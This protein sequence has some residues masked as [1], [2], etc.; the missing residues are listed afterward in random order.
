MA[1]PK[2]NKQQREEDLAYIA[3]LYLQGKTHVEIAYLVSADRQYTLTK[4]TIGRD[5]GELNDRWY[6]A[7]MTDIDRLKAVQ[8]AKVDE[9]EATAWEGWFKSLQDKTSQTTQDTEG[10]KSTSNTTQSSSGDPRFLKLIDNCIERRC[11]ILGIDAPAKVSATDNEGRPSAGSF[12]IL[13]AVAG[14]LDE[15]RAAVD[16]YEDENKGD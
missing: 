9:L 13:P 8:L 4:Q 14:S 1:A 10:M 6:Q 12:V 2:R 16:A 7:S 5:I 3:R 15:W 11:K